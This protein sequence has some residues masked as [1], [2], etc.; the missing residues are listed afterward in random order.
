MSTPKSHPKTRKI[1]RR[2]SPGNLWVRTRAYIAWF[3]IEIGGQKN[4][5][6]AQTST[7]QRSFRY[8]LPRIARLNSLA[9]RLQETADIYRDA[10]H[11]SI[12]AIKESKLVYVLREIREVLGAVKVEGRLRRLEEALDHA[13]RWV[14]AD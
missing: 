3:F 8:S 6:P 13:A 11:K 4:K 12:S 7:H 2:S 10:R 1:T 5:F 9:S 14:K